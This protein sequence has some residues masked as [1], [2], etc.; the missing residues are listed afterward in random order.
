MNRKYLAC[1]LTLVALATALIPGCGWDGHFDVF[2]YT[3]RPMYDLTIRSVRVPIFKNLSLRRNLEYQLTEAVISKI[4]SVTPYRV[5]QEADCADTELIGTIV[6]RSKS[7]INFNQL[8]EVR[9]AQTTMT[10]ELVWRDLRPGRAGEVLS[11]PLPGAP[12]DFPPPPPPP[13]AVA[14]PTQVQALAF[15]VPEIGGSLSTAEQ[16]MVDKLAVQI[17]SMMEKPW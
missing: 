7:V 11:K 4:Q 3:T 17:V 6:G 13:G 9:E 15:F 2:G 1:Y 5:V 16:E 14:P 10:V 12:G 8:G